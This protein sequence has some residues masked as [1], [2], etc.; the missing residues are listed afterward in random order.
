[1]DH[2]YFG[3]AESMTMSRPSYKSDGAEPPAEAAAA[4]AS[5]YMVFKDTGN[6]VSN[7]VVHPSI[8]KHLMDPLDCVCLLRP[9]PTYAQN[10]LARA[11][12]LFDLAWNKQTSYTVSNPF[13]K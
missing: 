6:A 10:L 3:T 4:L 11:R 2:A 8:N 7:D 5:G 13:Y 9:D 1:V 12:R